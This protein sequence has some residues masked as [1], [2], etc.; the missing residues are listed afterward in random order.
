MKDKQRGRL[1]TIEPN[2]AETHRLQIDSK[3]YGE[4]SALTKKL[5]TAVGMPSEPSYHQFLSRGSAALSPPPDPGF[6][7]SHQRLHTPHHFHSIPAWNRNAILPVHVPTISHSAVIHTRTREA[8]KA[9]HPDMERTW[10][11]KTTLDPC[12]FS[13]QEV[14]LS[15]MPTS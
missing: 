10:R 11:S 2:R 4:N 5:D 12:S 14:S 1:S 9:V 8:Q 6:N 7:E 15:T 13:W 3:T